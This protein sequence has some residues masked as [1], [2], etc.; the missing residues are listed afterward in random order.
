M[1][2]DLDCS[3]PG[4][5]KELKALPVTFKRYVFLHHKS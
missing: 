3:Q 2:G 1:K 5:S 4:L